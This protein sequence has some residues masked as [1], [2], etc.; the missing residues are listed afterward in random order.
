MWRTH[1]VT[2]YYISIYKV[3]ES[4]GENKFKGTWT[5]L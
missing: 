2:E 4:L 1:Y 5:I 3:C